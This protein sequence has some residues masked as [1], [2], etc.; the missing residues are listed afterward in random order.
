MTTRDIGLPRTPVQLRAR[1]VLLG[2]HQPITASLE[3]ELGRM[4]RANALFGAIP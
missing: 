1:I 3:K 4:E 2:E